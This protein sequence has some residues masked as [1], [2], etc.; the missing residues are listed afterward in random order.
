[1]AS[2]TEP[3]T[4]PPTS[5]SIP[6]SDLLEGL[7]VLGTV[8]RGGSGP[9]YGLRTDDGTELALSGSTAGT[10]EPGDR[11]RA[12]VRLPAERHVIDCGPGEPRILM[13][14]KRAT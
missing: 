12:L 8:T 2:P 7:W 5:D 9:C 1:M 4:K 14:V 10:L 13:Q 3:P 11:I 6:P